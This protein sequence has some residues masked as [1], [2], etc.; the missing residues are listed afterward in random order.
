M[1]DKV[2]TEVKKVIQG[3]DEIIKGV[4]SALL[5]GGHVLLEDV[6]GVGKTT[7]AIAIS[8]VLGLQ[9]NRI[10]FTPDVM[11]TD[12]TGFSMYNKKTDS[13]EYVPGSVMCN[14]LL[15]DEINRTSPKTQA[16]LLQVME[17]GKVTVDG[18]TRNV[19]KPF[20]VIATQNPYGSAGTQRLPQSQTDRFLMR[21]S[22]GY[23]DREGEIN[24]LKGKGMSNIDSLTEV[25]N[26]DDIARLQA[27]C[28]SVYVSEELY[29]MMTDIS[30]ATRVSDMFDM[31]ISPRG[32]LAILKCAKATAYME[33]R[34]YIVPEDIIAVIEPSCAHRVELSESAKLSGYD[35]ARALDEVARKVMRDSR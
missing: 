30:A 12:V 23:P 26:K 2:V 3:K 9:C 25:L 15:A 18:E 20:V 11:P 14:I 8:R 31:G 5:C 27:E 24:I 16:A 7:L 17:E 19:P 34:D 4:L 33:G 21:L 13:F 29:G 22:M 6:P 35:S 10:Q 1:I 32:T 28:D